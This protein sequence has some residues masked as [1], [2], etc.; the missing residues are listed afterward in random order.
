MKILRDAKYVVDRDDDANEVKINSKYFNML[1]NICDDM[2]L[3]I[4]Q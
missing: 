2:L 4:V 3:K 1:N